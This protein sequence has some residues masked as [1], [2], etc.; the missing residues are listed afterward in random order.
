MPLP[1]TYIN[2]PSREDRS[3]FVATRFA[4][5]LNESVLDVGCFE[6][7]LRNLL[8]LKSYIGIDIAGKPDIKLNLENIDRLPFEDDSF[9]SVLCIDVLEHLDNLHF[10]FDELIRV[11]KRFI[12]ISLPNCWSDARRPISRGKGRFKHYG[13]PLCK[14]VDRHKWFFSLTEA[15]EF[16]VYK[17][18]ELNLH[19]RDMFVTEKPRVGIIRL[20]RKIRYPGDRYQNRYSGTL[21]T[22]LEKI[23]SNSI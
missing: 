6:A 4:E 19:I 17:A 16:I 14:P 5:Y 1:T 2:F 10:I 21:W 11:S 20:L 9:M 12:I 23:K 13:L 22:V 18:T 7:P 15:K 8:N 3:R